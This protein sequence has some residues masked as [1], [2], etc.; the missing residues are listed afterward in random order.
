MLTHFRPGPNVEATKKDIALEQWV[1][2]GFSSFQMIF[3]CVIFRGWKSFVQFSR[4]SRS[5]GNPDTTQ[6]PWYYLYSHSY[7]LT[8]DIEH[9]SICLWCR[10]KFYTP[11]SVEDPEFY[12]WDAI[13]K[14]AATYYYLADCLR[15]LHENEEN[16][17]KENANET[18]SWIK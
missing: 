13:S 9:R 10:V 18:G 17:A 2:P 8:V 6:E 4:S 14:G 15:K 16:W 3:N 12:R 11:S 5:I 1:F 7:Q